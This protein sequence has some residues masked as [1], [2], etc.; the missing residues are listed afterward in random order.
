MQK[1]Q[2]YDNVQAFGSFVPLE[3]GG[4]ICVVKKKKKKKTRGTNK[5]MLV[6]YIDTHSTDKQPNYYTDSYKNDTREPKKWPIGGTVR[7]LVLDKDGNTSRGF[8]TF[9]EM[10][11]QSNPGFKVQWGDNF[12]NCFKG[13]LVGGVFGRE[14]YYNSYGEEKFSTKCTG[15]R[16]VEDVK[17]GRVEV[18][19]DKLLNPSNNSTTSSGFDDFTPVNDE[20]MPF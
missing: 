5:D 1:P 20:D 7:Q 13:K 12:C 4:H 3:L 11:E 16:T 14:Q 8:K 18:P 17:E 6:I 10:V 2:G 19:K 15:F 9:I